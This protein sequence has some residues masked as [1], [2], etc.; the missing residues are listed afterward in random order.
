MTTITKYLDDLSRKLN[1]SQKKIVGIIVAAIFLLLPWQSLMKSA[2]L[3][4]LDA[5]AGMVVAE[6]HLIWKIRGI[7]G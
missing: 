2:L 5:V 7:F 4:D 3:V 1:Q 6:D